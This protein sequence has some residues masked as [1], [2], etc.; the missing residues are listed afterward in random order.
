MTLAFSVLDA[1]P[2]P[3]AAVPTLVFRMRVADD[4]GEPV[5]AVALRTQLRIEPQRRAYTD[6]EAAGL[7]DQFGGR[8]RWQE[9]LRPFLWTHA[10]ATLRGFSDDL[11]FDLPVPCT[12]D[13]EVIGTKYLHAL[14][15][16]DVPVALLFSGTLFRPGSGASGFGVEQVPW[17]LEASYR[18]PVAVWRAVMDQ[19]F[20]DSGWLRLSR[21]TLDALIRYRSE[22]GLTTWDATIERLFSDQRV[23]R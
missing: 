10:A 7:V 9:T 8:A 2:E 4:S 20:P 1:L 19:Y 21:D 13:L 5:S 16:G 22:H 3:Y 23:P 14:R 6:D 17:H 11:E 12:Y 15:D 18:L